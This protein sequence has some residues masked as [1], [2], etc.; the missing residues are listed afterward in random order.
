MMSQYYCCLPLCVVMAMARG[1]IG[2]LNEAI[3]DL[4]DL[5]NIM[6]SEGDINLYCPTLEFIE[7]CGKET[8]KCFKSELFVLGFEFDGLLKQNVSQLIGSLN[9]KLDSFISHLK[10]STG[11][12]RCEIY[13]E[14]PAKVFLSNL[15]RF[16][17]YHNR[18]ICQKL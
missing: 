10:A 14:E 16:L 18:Y 2:C 7:I 1:T 12:Q 15:I 3:I 11:C 5:R 13:N 6:E 8:L 17:Q 9:E 4:V